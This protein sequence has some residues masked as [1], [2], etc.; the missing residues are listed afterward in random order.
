MF[1]V[2]AILIFEF[3]PKGGSDG[4]PRPY[5]GKRNNLLAQGMG[6]V[7]LGAI[8]MFLLKTF[9][10]DGGIL[11]VWA[12]WAALVGLAIMLVGGVVLVALSFAS[13]A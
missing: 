4:A 3:F 11:P 8:G 13:R 1:L 9:S 12:Y 6:N 10:Q 7:F 2:Y 5:C